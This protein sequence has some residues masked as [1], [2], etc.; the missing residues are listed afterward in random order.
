MTKDTDWVKLAIEQIKSS[1]IQ[2]QTYNMIRQRLLA[3]LIVRR[4]GECIALIGPSRVGKSS[5]ARELEMIMNSDDPDE[6]MTRRP[7]VRFT[8][9]NP[10]ESG[11][12]TTKAFYLEALSAIRHPVFTV[13][14]TDL[15][16]S[17]KAFRKLDRETNATLA[18]AMEGALKVLQTKYLVIDETQHLNYMIGGVRS[19]LKMMEYFKTL[20]EKLDIVLIFVGAYPIV[21][22]LK[23]S[24]HL[25]GRLCV[26]EMKRYSDEREEDLVSFQQVLMWFSD[27]VRFKKGIAG[28]SDWNKELYEGSFGVIGLLSEWIRDALAEVMARGDDHLTIEHMRYVLKALPF[29]NE[30]WCEIE[31][32]ETFMSS[33]GEVQSSKSAGDNNHLDG[34]KKRK[35]RT[36]PFQAPVK[37]RAVGDR[38]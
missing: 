3:E 24:P 38:T 7:V 5:L 14:G 20:A 25:L 2:H 1:Q 13:E 30:M 37:R 23:L 32:G 10:G 6:L 19:S 16:E 34:T 35:K 27:H 33:T 31:D 28:F 17:V 8:C 21:H 4:G 15:E 26:V 22:V 36:R 9:R 29:R 18:S 11:F 12:F